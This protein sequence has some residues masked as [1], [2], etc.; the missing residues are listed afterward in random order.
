M[1]MGLKILAC[2][3]LPFLRLS[4]VLILVAHRMEIFKLNR[5]VF[6]VWN[7]SFWEVCNLPVSG[8]A[9]KKLLHCFKYSHRGKKSLLK[10]GLESALWDCFVVWKLFVNTFSTVENIKLF[11]T[12]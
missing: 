4:T 5:Y 3:A 6:L 1:V 10:A 2:S 12:M 8:F 7:F 11:Y 9:G